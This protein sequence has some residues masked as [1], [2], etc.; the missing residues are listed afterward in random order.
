[1]MSIKSQD[2]IKANFPNIILPNY[3]KRPSFE[4]DFEISGQVVKRKPYKVSKEKESWMKEKISFLKNQGIIEDSSSSYASPCV[5]IPKSNGTF[6]LCQDYREINK[7]TELDPFPFPLIDNIINGFG[8][9]NY[10]TKIDLKD[11][12]YQVGISEKTRKF[13]AFVTPFGHFQFRRL[14]FGW[15]NSPPKFQRIMMRI[16][17]KL[18]IDP[19]VRVYIDDICIGS[20]TFEENSKKTSKVLKILNDFGFAINTEK[21]YFNEPHVE[22]LGRIIDGKC[23]VTKIES[24]R[25][26]LNMRKP[27]D[28]HSVRC[29]T[30]LTGHFRAYIEN[31]ANVVRPLD[32]LKQKDKPFIWNEECER[33]YQL[34]LKKITENPILC[35]PDDELPFELCTDASHYGTGSILYQRNKN[36][37]KGKQ[38]KVV[39]YQSYTFT[40]PEINYST[41]EKEALAVIKSLKYFRGLIE[42]KHVIIHTDHQALTFILKNKEPKGRLG[43]W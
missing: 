29:F 1:M 2:D 28:L 31:Y 40:K 37:V 8:G 41:T 19:T 7:L 43:R 16:L 27:F 13:T 4:I 23:K 10:F 3:R 5:I 11:G 39:G 6:R 22:F 25:K 34:L 12:F 35:V 17:E 26:V 14:P 33:S 20:R 38:L 18:L 9:C 15:K 24:I 30:G 36:E 42:S 21:C 32:A